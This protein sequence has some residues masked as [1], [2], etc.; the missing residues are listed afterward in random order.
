MTCA[1]S[2][3]ALTVA[4]AAVDALLCAVTIVLSVTSMTAHKSRW[5][6]A[7]YWLSIS[8]VGTWFVAWPFLWS[9]S[10]HPSNSEKVAIARALLVL[11]FACCFIALVLLLV[12]SVLASSRTTT[13][14]IVGLA[15]LSLM[16]ALVGV[17][18]SWSLVPAA[19]VPVA[20][21]PAAKEEEE[22]VAPPKR[23]IPVFAFYWQGGNINEAWFRPLT[24]GF[25]S[26]LNKVASSQH[27][28][29]DLQMV[30]EFS[31][32]T[33]STILDATRKSKPLV[34]WLNMTSLDIMTGHGRMLDTL[35]LA[36]GNAPQF[37]HELND[38]QSAVTC[39]LFFVGS[40]E[41]SPGRV[42]A[43]HDE[44]EENPKMP[45][46]LRPPTFYEIGKKDQKD[47]TFYV[48]AGYE[49]LWNSSYLGPVPEN[50]KS[51]ELTYGDEQHEQM[52]KESEEIFVHK[53]IQECL[54]VT[55]TS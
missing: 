22:S 20:N 14:W 27:V 43:I 30:K 33:Q 29:F 41:F 49:P 54:G 19:K 7:A 51:V 11:H 53:V 10:C 5:A 15:A 4:V 21:V 17:A 1:C 34:L 26:N 55:T 9:L 16:L 31:E 3:I 28:L 52:N 48:A 39:V 42:W 46:Y 18:T 35:R 44:D 36:R 38:A 2:T 24:N 40:P 23:T 8:S 50:V 12:R 47:Q 45:V 13:K 32:T 6:Q 37:I 25:V